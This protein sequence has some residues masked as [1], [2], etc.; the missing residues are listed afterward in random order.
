MFGDNAFEAH[1]AR[2][3]HGLARALVR[4]GLAPR[5]DRVVE[6]LGRLARD[7]RLVVEA[8]RAGGQ[9]GNLV[10]YKLGLVFAYR[11]AGHPRSTVAGGNTGAGYVVFSQ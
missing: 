10:I 9:P 11:Q 2:V 5:L 7:A 3:D 4:E 1:L 8:Q 6:R